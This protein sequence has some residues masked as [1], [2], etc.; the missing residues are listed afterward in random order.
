M[1]KTKQSF[2]RLFDEARHLRDHL[3]RLSGHDAVDLTNALRPFEKS[4]NFDDITDEQIATLSTAFQTAHDSTVDLIDSRT[5]G[6]ILSGKSPH[7]HGDSTFASIGLAIIGLILVIGAFH[8]TYWSNKTQI[9]VVQAEQFVDFDHNA[10]MMKVVELE[11][12]FS[13]AGAITPE[14][15]LASGDIDPELVYLE[16]FAQ[17]ETQYAVEASLPVGL[18]YQILSFNPLNVM[19]DRLK[20]RICGARFFDQSNRLRVAFNCP[21]PR[22]VVGPLR[23]L[24]QTPISRDASSPQPY[25]INDFRSKVRR[26]GLMETA[27]MAAAGRQPINPYTA[28]RQSVDNMRADLVT[29]LSIVRLWALPIIYGALGS[30]VY[31]MWRVLDTNV[32]G[33]G[34][35]LPVMRT[36]FAGLAALTFSMLLVPANVLSIGAEMNR[37]IIYLLSFIFGYSIE[38]FISTLNVIN[39]YVMSNVAVKPRKPS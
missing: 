15:A 28:S 17:L 23:Q 30:I 36:T 5:L 14:R 18:S 16:Q 10:Q 29:K 34:F 26:I 24:A 12:L 3:L 2:D 20:R 1:D 39:T 7:L 38:A 31:C 27:T 19:H 11:A 13:E 35:A 32:S 6:N 8:Y 37:P 9:L 25:G 4:T 22:A 33:L 21:E